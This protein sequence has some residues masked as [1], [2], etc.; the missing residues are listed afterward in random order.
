MAWIEHPHLFLWSWKWLLVLKL[1][2][3]W[4]FN[5]QDIKVACP[6]LKDKSATR[7]FAEEDDFFSLF[8]FSSG[9]CH[10]HLSKSRIFIISHILASPGKKAAGFYTE[11]EPDCPCVS[12]GSPMVMSHKHLGAETQHS[13]AQASFHT[14]EAT[15]VPSHGTSLWHWRSNLFLPWQH[16]LGE[17]LHW[18][19]ISCCSGAM[20]IALSPRGGH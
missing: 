19:L 18:A 13:V 11:L 10:R 14:H 4:V 8:W 20:R 15:L 17:C 12:L 2:N 1:Q 9:Y 7:L 5:S 3:G 6:K 16:F